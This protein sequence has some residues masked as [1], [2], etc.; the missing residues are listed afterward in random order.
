ME[1]D[2]GPG[3]GDDRV[4]DHR[5]LIN[6]QQIH[7][8]GTT[9]LLVA[10]NA[11]GSQLSQGDLEALASIQEELD[12]M[13]AAGQTINM[14]VVHQQANSHQDIIAEEIVGHH[15]HI[16][17]GNVITETVEDTS[18]LSSLATAAL[19]DSNSI[20]VI[21]EVS[22]H[23]SQVLIQDNSGEIGLGER[24][25]GREG[26]ILVS[27]EVGGDMMVTGD[28]DRI[29]VSSGAGG[30]MSCG[31]MIISSDQ[32]SIN[33]NMIEEIST[34]EMTSSVEEMVVTSNADLRTISSSNLIVR[35]SPTFRYTDHQLQKP[36]LKVIKRPATNTL[37][38][39]FNKVRL[40]GDGGSQQMRIVTQGDQGFLGSSLGAGGMTI[41]GQHLRVINTGGGLKTIS[42][43]DS[44]SSQVKISQSQLNQLTSQTQTISILNADGSTSPF[45][46]SVGQQSIKILNSDGTLSSIA[47][48]GGQSTA[49]MTV[50][51]AQ[52]APQP[53][54]KILNADGTLTT[55]G[56]ASHQQIRIL[57]A[58]GSLSDINPASLS[59]SF[60]PR[61]T[62]IRIQPSVKSEEPVQFIRHTPGSI[63]SP[64]KKQ[65]ISFSQAQQLGILPMV[66]KTMISPSKVTLSRAPSN[67]I[68][69]QD[70]RVLTM[71]SP[72]KHLVNLT[73]PTKQV[74]IKNSF[75][76]TVNS[77]Q[78]QVGQVI[79]VPVESSSS[80]SS[81][82]GKLQYVRVVN[83]AGQA[84]TMA[85]RGS[86]HILPSQVRSGST[87]TQERL[88]TITPSVHGIKSVVPPGLHSPEELPDSLQLSSENKNILVQ[89]HT[90]QY[91]DQFL[92]K[93][94][95]IPT[96]IEPQ[97]IR[98][99]KPCNCTKSQCLKLY[100]DCFA[101]GEFCHNCN[102]N[103]C[104][105]NLAHEE[106]RQKSIKQCLDRNPNAFRPKIGK[107][108]SEGERRHNKGCN[109]KRSGCL[110][111]YCECYEAKIPC[112]DA[113]K[114]AGCKN[115]DEKTGMKVR[116]VGDKQEPG[117]GLQDSEK[118]FKPTSSLRSKLL[119]TPTS[120][121]LA[122]KKEPAGLR[123]PFS[124]VTTDVVE[125]TCQCLLAQA[126]ECEKKGS[127]DTEME[128]LILEE[129]GRC[130]VQIIDFA[131][132]C[133]ITSDAK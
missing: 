15:D 106:A 33:D 77:V 88:L 62:S 36:T 52:P 121:D 82:S 47:N 5:D 73:S 101:N 79:R 123:Q 55:P 46:F 16:D 116:V 107:V 2:P 51:K 94:Q 115:L 50:L 6:I 35:N 25:S 122:G 67:T 99:R 43:P 98:P 48:V 14:D 76:Q 89:K 133:K 13:A 131:G 95:R 19:R 132:K 32:D 124:F 104:F 87:P 28:R 37:G 66:T 61:Q 20:M 117:Q 49:P 44:G 113:C 126:E 118:W 10:P 59:S 110:K 74:F 68:R 8:G 30:E 7:H 29:L 23:E 24:F 128:H 56:P 81:G 85:V 92:R 75:G 12:R 57:N 3:P 18:H 109:C 78:K 45:P 86:Q 31:E 54:I 69:T 102:C 70:G 63:S 4:F 53:Q 9:Q 39:V 114:C 71:A 65:K 111:N 120:L 105:N 42:M 100:C 84:Q 119:Q 26:E 60:Q 97:G 11:D 1:D 64:I 129:F 17:M 72:N 112:T 58:D 22:H 27:G 21:P 34:E 127:S 108:T 93:E 41:G 80:Q 40:G 38:Q 91:F 130:L 103:N 96:P 83:S 90:D 125:A